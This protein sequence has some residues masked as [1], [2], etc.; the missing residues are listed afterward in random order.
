[1]KKAAA[2][3][4]TVSY[5]QVNTDRQESSDVLCIAWKP[6]NKRFG[7]NVGSGRIRIRCTPT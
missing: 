4:I 6:V 1:M 3:A 2:L 7:S 5:Q